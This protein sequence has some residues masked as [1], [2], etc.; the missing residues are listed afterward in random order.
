MRP[1]THNIQCEIGALSLKRDVL[2]KTQRT[3][4]GKEAERLQ[5]PMVIYKSKKT[6]VFQIQQ[7]Q[8]T[9]ELTDSR[10]TEVQIR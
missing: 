3:Y 1:T 10:P 5:K 2:V 4:V 9:Y 7:G 8:C 6:N